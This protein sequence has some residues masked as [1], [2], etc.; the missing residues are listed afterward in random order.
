MFLPIAGHEIH[1][2]E[3]GPPDAPAVVMWH[4]LARTGRDFDTLA[5][6]LAA[7]RRVICPDTVGRGLSSW[8]AKPAEDY[9][10]AAYVAH[11]IE[12]L[13]RLGIETLDWVG[14][15]MGG[16]IGMGAAAGPLKGRIR[17]L[18]MN[19]IGP[20]VNPLAIERI[21]QYVTLMPAFATM[22][23]FEGFCRFAYAPFGQLTAAEWRTLAET[24]ARR[25]D[26]GTWTMHYDPQVMAVFAAEIAHFDAWAVY[27][28]VDCPTLVLR[29]AVSD[30]LPVE[31]A[32]A[33]TARGPTATLVTVEG[34]GH[35]PALNTAEQMAVVAGFLAG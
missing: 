2:T 30:L 34:C 12:L 11:T 22:A 21:R 1:V 20:V 19:D 27:E 33:M 15:S 32:Q 18:V 4:G 25:R 23:E 13:E 24:S 6:H 7:T 35:A 3:W 28:A 29:G 26:D 5:A 9:T 16:L 17:R 14:T 10:V 31:T 8:S